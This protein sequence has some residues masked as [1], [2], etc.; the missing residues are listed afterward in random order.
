MVDAKGHYK[1]VNSQY[2]F[3]KVN[4]FFF[5]GMSGKDVQT[6]KFQTGAIKILS[7]SRFKQS[8]TAV[9]RSFNVHVNN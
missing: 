4:P 3:H 2:H 8:T 5:N 9:V 1:S 7:I 6:G